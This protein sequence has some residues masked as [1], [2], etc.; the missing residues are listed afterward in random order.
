MQVFAEL[1][2]HNVAL[3]ALAKSK[4]KVRHAPAR[5][6]ADPALG[7]VEHVRYRT[8]ERL[9]LPNRKNPVTFPPNSPALFL[10][11]RVRDE[12]HRF[13]ITYHRKLRKV[14]NQRSVLEEI[15]GVGAKRK[16]LLLRHFGS[17]AAVKAAPEQEIARVE[18]IGEV[19]AHA[20]YEFLHSPLRPLQE[21]FLEASPPNEELELSESEEEEGP[22]SPEE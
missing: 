18:G 6:N 17:L 14:A 2:L 20:I 15:P 5:P 10:V 7:S 16:R 12:A 3:A 13:A 8:E 1:G 19:A 22:Q 21:D 4:L 11:Q 9:F